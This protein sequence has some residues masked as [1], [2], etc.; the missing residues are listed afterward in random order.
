MQQNFMLSD[1]ASIVSASARTVYHVHI[2]K[3]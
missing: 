3:M 1:E 2:K